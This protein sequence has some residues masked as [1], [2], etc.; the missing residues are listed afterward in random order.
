VLAVVKSLALLRQFQ[1]GRERD[2]KG[3]LIATLDDYRV[4]RELLGGWART[5]LGGGIS[6]AAARLFEKV[7]EG[8]SGQVFNRKDCEDLM[9]LSKRAINK[10]LRELVEAGLLQADYICGGSASYRVVPSATLEQV[11][12]LPRQDDL[13]LAH[14]SHL[15]AN[16]GSLTQANTYDG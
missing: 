6:D 3:S 13:L 12:P 10:L 9:G 4:T 7:K 14:H 16:D 11:N 8:F 5:E 1:P 15:E 2:E